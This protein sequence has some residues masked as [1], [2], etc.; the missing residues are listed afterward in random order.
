MVI[1][2]TQEVS[3]Q[4]GIPR[5]TVPFLLVAFQAKF[6]GAGA[7]GVGFR[8]V[9][10]VVEHEHVTRRSFRGDDAWVLRHEASAIHFS[11]VVDFD[12]DFDLSA[13]G[14]KTAKF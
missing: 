4:V 13:H 12:L 5:E 8:W 11:F 1:G 9:L 7:A 3:V 10:R 6:G 2:G 14:S